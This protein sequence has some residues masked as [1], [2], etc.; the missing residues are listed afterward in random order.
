MAFGEGDADLHRAA[1]PYRIVARQKGSPIRQFGDHVLVQRVHLAFGLEGVDSLAIAASVGRGFEQGRIQQQLGDTVAGAPRFD[2]SPHDSRQAW[3]RRVRNKQGFLFRNRDHRTNVFRRYRDAQRI[4]GDMD[5]LRP[6]GTVAA[7]RRDQAG[8]QG[9]RLGA[10]ELWPWQRGGHLLWQ[11]RL[12]RRRHRIALFDG[13]R[14][15][16][17]L[18]HG[19]S[20]NRGFGWHLRRLPDLGRAG[21]CAGAQQGG[22]DCGGEFLVAGQLHRVS[23]RR[24]GLRA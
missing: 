10:V 20:R 17:G 14:Q 1:G 24:D 16:H 18:R 23:G 4:E 2:L 19:G 22:D 8:N 12:E 7:P 6:A 5:V 11:R 9:A 3:N 15:G 21:R 13:R